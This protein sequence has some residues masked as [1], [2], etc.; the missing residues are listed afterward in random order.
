MDQLIKGMVLSQQH[1]VELKL[2]FI[3]DLLGKYK[4]VTT[5]KNE[6]AFKK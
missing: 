6:Q 5:N 1:P 4:M 2:A 3:K